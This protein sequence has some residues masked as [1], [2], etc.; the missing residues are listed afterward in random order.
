V[1][2]VIGASFAT[3]TGAPN[4]SITV[5]RDADTTATSTGSGANVVAFTCTGS[6]CDFTKEPETLAFTVTFPNSSG[7]ISEADIFFNPNTCFT[8]D[9]GG[10]CPTPSD[11]PQD[12]QTVATHEIG[13]FFGLDHTGVVRAVMFPFAPDVETKLAEDDVAGISFLYP[14]GSQD[15]PT[16]SI[17]GTVTLGGNGVFGAHV[18]AESTGSTAPF[19]GFNI[20]KSPISTFTKTDGTYNITGVPADPAGY[21]VAAE[22]VDLPL[23]NGDIGW[24]GTFL[25]SSVQTGFTTR[26]H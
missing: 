14:K 24:A 1:V 7:V 23:A 22:P 19:P 17:S 2:T 25:R 8:T 20:R 11:T 10:T 12:L 26:W 15:V 21:T 16:G 6:N 4:T 18:Y 13:H 5:Q 3:W 9:G